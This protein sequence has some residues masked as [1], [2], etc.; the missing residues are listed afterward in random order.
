MRFQ[1][2]VFKM[3]L[4]KSDSRKEYFLSTSG[5]IHDPMLKRLGFKRK[6]ELA[7][8]NEQMNAIIT[9]WFR[10]KQ[11]KLILI[12]NTDWFPRNRERW[13]G[14]C[15]FVG[16]MT[17]NF[18]SATREYDVDNEGVSCK[19]LEMS[20]N[21][22]TLVVTDAYYLEFI[23]R[24]I[25]RN[26]SFA[27]SLKTLEF[28]EASLED[29]EKEIRFLLKKMPNLTQLKLP[30]MFTREPDF[31]KPAP[32]DLD[33][34]LNVL[35]EH[36]EAKG[37]KMKMLNLGLP[38]DKKDANFAEKIKQLALK[39]E[40]ISDSIG[41]TTTESIG[42]N[43]ALTPDQ[44]RSILIRFENLSHL[45]MATKTIED[46]GMAD[47]YRAAIESS[48]CTLESLELHVHLKCD[49]NEEE[50]QQFV[51]EILRGV[52]AKWPNLKEFQFFTG[53]G[54]YSSEM[55]LL[56]MS[57]FNNIVASFPNVAL[58][59]IGAQ[60]FKA[61][62][63]TS[64]IPLNSNVKEFA[65]RCVHKRTSNPLPLLAQILNGFPNLKALK[66]PLHGWVESEIEEWMQGYDQQ[67]PYVFACKDSLQTLS[68]IQARAFDGDSKIG[69]FFSLVFRSL[70]NIRRLVIKDLERERKKN[71]AIEDTLL[72]LNQNLEYLPKL[73][74]L[75]VLAPFIERA[76]YDHVYP[77]KM[78]YFTPALLAQLNELMISP[79]SVSIQSLKYF[80][81]HAPKLKFMYIIGQDEKV[82]RMKE[83][84]DKDENSQVNQYYKEVR[85]ML[86]EYKASNPDS[87]VF[88][89]GHEN[90]TCD[91]ESD[92]GSEEKS[93]SEHISDSESD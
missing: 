87:F 35:K 65:L 92:S 43:T 47:A 90:F 2:H 16:A 59:K 72:S 76:T 91:F 15:M 37:S 12:F 67:K 71:P 5:V 39:C 30:F 41:L 79:I 7:D 74:H 60:G 80:V 75:T 31:F 23:I 51:R 88:W 85:S 33:K 19:L 18:C 56:P 68:I 89:D 38:F 32:V 82:R 62:D 52:S 20:S 55:K 58:L 84:D 70:P 78:N 22:E 27:K 3:S 57:I 93:L 9:S 36:T 8:L 21:L 34:I 61:Y 14:R 13:D 50:I 53:C 40:N 81:Q 48:V 29:K 42:M 73:K 86:E 54:F 66:I 25:Q 46:I 10:R 63:E 64:P 6:L 28:E 24:A 45:E 26:D 69:K 83:Y 1:F 77:L 49:R 11:K 17:V 44:L 4:S